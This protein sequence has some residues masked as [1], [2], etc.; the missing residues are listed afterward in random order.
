MYIKKV[1]VETCALTL[2]FIKR[3]K[4]TDFFSFII[5][6][7]CSLKYTL[8]HPKFKKKLKGNG[9]KLKKSKV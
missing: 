1:Y 3:M 4:I 7:N 5:S 8:Q 9:Q 6:V 2:I